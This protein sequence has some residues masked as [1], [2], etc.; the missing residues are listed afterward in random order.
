[1]KVG[2]FFPP[3]KRERGS[4][5][6]LGH[7]KRL[8]PYVRQ[9]AWV[10]SVSVGG[11]LVTR[12]FDAIV[13]Q[14]MRTAIDSLVEPD[15]PSNVLWPA[16]GILGVVAVRFGIY[17]WARRLLRRVSISVSYDLRRRLFDHIQYQGAAFFN[18]YGTGDLMSRAVND[19]GMVQRVVS[20]G[21]VTIVMFFFS[22]GTGLYFMIGMSPALTAWVVLPMPLVAI[23][24]FVMARGMFPYFR[25]QQE[26]QAAIASFTQENLNGIRT[27][28]AAAQED[29]EIRRFRE[30]STVFADKV[31]RATRYAAS[32]KLMMPFLSMISIVVVL[33]Y[34]GTL[35]QRG[36]ITVGTF[37]AFFA[38]LA[39]VTGSVSSIGMSVQ[40][41]TSAAAGTQRIFELLDSEPEIVETSAED[42]PQ[43]IRGDL[44][45]RGLSYRYPEAARSALEGI[46]LHVSSGE[47]IAF[48]GRV[49]S[50]KSTLLRAVVR[51]VDTPAG[52]VFLDGRDVCDYPLH[53]LREVVTLVPQDPFLFSATLRANLSYDDPSRSDEQIWEAAE[54]AGLA[55]TIRELSEGL[56]TVVG[57]RGIT[58]SGGQRQRATLAR[59]LIRE[60]PVLLMDDCFSSVDTATEELILSGLERMRE[61]KTT[62]LISHRVSTARHANRIFVLDEGRVL[63]S[64]T[65]E[66]LLALGGYYA[67]LEAVQR[68]QDQDRARKDRLVRNLQDSQEREEPAQRGEPAVASTES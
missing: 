47:T 57:E 66:E 37:S 2:A 60:A 29:E 18:R 32:M 8:G 21:W 42:L 61:G 23:A 40:M 58:L 52:R 31:Y 27:I 56:D 28:Q 14:F 33:F 30:V 5:R 34:G 63:E 11:L 45:F 59:G 38:Y 68:N 54:A 12:F 6:H 17:V 26:A 10:L 22:I 35:V 50:G 53:R 48:L 41:F 39:M 55:Q 1:M 46:D 15:T 9:Y 3:A 4:F 20:F 49:G 7:L 36:E 19:V 67:D 43:E 62:L 13:P 16:V 64:G 44:E 25:A 51:L 24:G 65:H